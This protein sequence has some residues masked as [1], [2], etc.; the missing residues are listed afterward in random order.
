M[1]SLEWLSTFASIYRAGSVSDAARQR[2]ITQSALSQQL[3]GLE[4]LI[5]TRLF[6]RNSRGMT[7][8]ERGR[9]L[10]QEVFEAIDCLDRVGQSLVRSVSSD[11]KLRFGTS[12]EYF[13]GFA[14]E[15]IGGLG[16]GLSVTLA[17]DRELLEGLQT[18]GLDF[19]ATV[20]K[21]TSRSIQFNVL[22]DE[23]YAL[24]GPSEHEVPPQ[25]SSPQELAQ[26]LNAK[27]WV[28]YSEE[29]PITRRFWQQA[30]GAKFAAKAALVV[31]DILTVVAAV[32]LGIGLTIVPEYLCRKALSDGR[33]QA[34]WPVGD[35]IPTER[36]YA[37]CR[38]TDSERF[39][40]AILCN[41]LLVRP[42]P[43]L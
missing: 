36:R 25:D 12:P 38:R 6:D 18:G 27:P 39:E 26:W 3:A 9:A 22:G 17:S 28:S 32:E 20:T 19:I 1:I 8:T 11:R 35:L 23:P 40:I 33:V 14:L 24:I 29:R 21:P 7:P 31:P 13:H 16:H 10:Y 37:C 2:R 4:A 41:S 43:L 34:L 15:R 30:L 42:K 5:G